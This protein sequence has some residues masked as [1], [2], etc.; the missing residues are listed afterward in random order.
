M[1]PALKGFLSRLEGFLL[2][3]SQEAQH[4]WDYASIIPQHADNA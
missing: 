4:S 2:Q 3:E 1:A